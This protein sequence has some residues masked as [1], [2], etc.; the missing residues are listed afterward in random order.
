MNRRQLLIAVASPWAV[1]TVVAGDVIPPYLVGVWATQTSQLNG[2]ILSEGEALYLGADGIGAAVGGAPPKGVK[3]TAVFSPFSN[4]IE[5]DAIE[6]GNVVAHGSVKYD[7]AT[8]SIDTGHAQS[9]RL[10]RRLNEFSDET[11]K[12]LGL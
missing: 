10:Y 6:A 1:T 9:H 4:R 3:I 2:S 8:D 12:A 11:R 5:Y 7:P